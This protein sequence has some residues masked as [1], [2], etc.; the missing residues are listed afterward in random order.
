MSGDNKYS[1][2]KIFWH[3][4]KLAA[5][6]E[7]QVTAPIYVRIKPTNTCNHRCFYCSYQVDY[8][9]VRQGFDPK[10]RIPAEKLFEI[11]DNFKEMKVKAITYSGGGEPLLHPDIESVLARTLE[12]GIDLSIITNGQFIT[13]PIAELLTQAQWVRISLDSASSQ[14]FADTR[15]VPEDI[16]TT[17][18]RNIETFSKKKNAGCE[19]GINFVVQEKNC[20]EVYDAIK[21]FCNLGVNHIKVTARNTPDFLQYHESFRQHVNEQINKGQS[22]FSRK[23]F[24]VINKYESD[25]DLAGVYQ[26]TYERCLIIETVPIIAADQRVYHCH[27]K[28][29]STIDY[30]GSI[31]DQSFKALWFSDATKELFSTF[32]PKKR[33]NHHCTFDE[34]NILLNKFLATKGHHTNFI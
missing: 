11:L 8:K 14:I 1:N 20:N 27:D 18:C 33:C 17:I 12:Y 6:G 31:A 7:N 16:F 22:D 30:I 4:E 9:H 5:F 24:A 3:A 25:F 32:N 29:Y 10:L 13:G 15:G 28:A 34:R 21:L 26:R 23:G 19:L 2:L